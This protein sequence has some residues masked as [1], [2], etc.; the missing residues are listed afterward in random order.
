MSKQDNSDPAFSRQGTMR[1][2]PDGDSRLL[3]AETFNDG[4]SLRDYLA[5]KALQGMLAYSHIN[6]MHGNWVENSSEERAASHAYKYA[7]A[8]LA[9]RAKEPRDA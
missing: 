9:E 5:A 4:M 7:D 1:S 8:M 3:I 2:V 6:P